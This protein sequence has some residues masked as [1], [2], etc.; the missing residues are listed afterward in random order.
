[1]KRLLLIILTVLYLATGAQA[2]DIPVS[3]NAN[4]EAD[5]AG[6]KV[7][8]GTGTGV[9]ETTIDVENITSYIV[10]LNPEIKT[11]YFFAVTAYDT[12]G[13]ESPF[14]NE[15]S[16]EVPDEFAPAAP[17]GFQAI[18]QAIIS[19]FRGLFGLSVRVV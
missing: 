1:M 2:A 13:N 12:S 9:Y 4:E 5:L 14:S 18:I 6:Y 15:A 8:Y 16:I 7:Y 19:W 10:T 3:W 17:T 11:E